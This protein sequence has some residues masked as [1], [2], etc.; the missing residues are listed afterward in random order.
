LTKIV[1]EGKLVENAES[2]VDNSKTHATVCYLPSEAES[3]DKD[4]TALR[5]VLMAL[6]D[7]VV[8][9]FAIIAK[10]SKMELRNLEA[11]VKAENAPNS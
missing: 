6:A 10:N 4:P 3:T 1:A 9:V 5:W 8:I 2:V 11:I 7:Y